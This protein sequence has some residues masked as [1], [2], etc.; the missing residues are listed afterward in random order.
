[1]HDTLHNQ[2]FYF[3]PEI[4]PERTPKIYL[5]DMSRPHFGAQPTT[6][7]WKD[8]NKRFNPHGIGTWKNKQGKGK[9]KVIPI[10]EKLK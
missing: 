4:F 8:E 1:M 10:H 3:Q 2:G 9:I 6:I 7:K 5:L